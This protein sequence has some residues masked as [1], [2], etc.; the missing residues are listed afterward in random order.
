MSEA[1]GLAASLERRLPLG[2]PG[3]D[4]IFLGGLIPRRSYLLAGQPGAGKTI[5]AF[6]WLREMQRRGLRTQYISL[7]EAGGEIRRNMATFGWDLAGIELLDLTP[8]DDLDDMANGDYRIFP[9]SEVEEASSWGAIFRS[10]REMQ[11]ECLVLDSLTLLRSLSPDEYQFRKKVM[12]LVSFLNRIQCTAILT[13]EV[14]DLEQEAGVALAVDGLIRLR[15]EVSP[16]RVVALRSVQIDKFRGS[17]FLS[18]YHALRITPAGIVVY[19]HRIERTGPDPIS[20]AQLSSGSRELDELLGGGLEVHTTTIISGPPGT[21]KTT[22]GVEFLRTAAEAG[23]TAALFCFEES[24]ESIV[25]RARAIGTPLD[26]HIAS[27]KLQ[28]RRSNVLEQYPDEFLAQVRQ[29]VEQN[30]V[31]IVMVD[32][33]RGYK[34]EMEQFGSPLNHIHNMI[35]YLHRNGVTCLIINEYESIT[36]DVQATEM[37]ISHLAE[38]IILMRYAEYQGRIIKVVTCLKKRLGTF[39]SELRELH[40]GSDG[41]SV[42]DKL[43]QLNG[44]LTG[45]PS[46]QPAARRAE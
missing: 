26:A 22:L 18:G 38:N 15:C 46:W 42:G 45:V 2:I 27:G 29:A 40:I 8:R 34:L 37:G 1:S 23:Q 39:Q 14:S 16:S 17:D 19:P 5:F 33:L 25:Y 20:D 28:I 41:F 21:G 31:R 13:F 43:D 35:H 6:Q 36:G 7:A 11:P 12:N 24:V 9:P 4:E 44:V 30:G 32:S 3:L 10:V